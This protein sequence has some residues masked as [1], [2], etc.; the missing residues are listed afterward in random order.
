V[1][2]LV[3]DALGGNVKRGLLHLLHIQ[4]VTCA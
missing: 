3:D 4:S 1:I 2:D